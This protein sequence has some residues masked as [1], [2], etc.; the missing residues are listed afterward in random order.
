MDHLQQEQLRGPWFGW[1]LGWVPSVVEQGRSWG[2]S[3]SP[4]T[5][6]AGKVELGDKIPMEDKE[7]RI[8]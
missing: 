7:V 8:G 6:F 2:S 4:V 3:R 5:W 1:S